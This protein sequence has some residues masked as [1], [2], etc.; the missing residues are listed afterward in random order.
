MHNRIPIK[1]TNVIPT[2]IDHIQ[3]N[4]THAGSSAMLYAFED[5]E[6]IIK[7]IKR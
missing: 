4:T 1:H 7:M 5:D 2:N 6:A 3:S